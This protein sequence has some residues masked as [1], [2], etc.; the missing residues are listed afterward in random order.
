METILSN[1]IEPIAILNVQQLIESNILQEEYSIQS[2][3][4]I[5]DKLQKTLTEFPIG[6]LNKNMENYR[7]KFYIIRIYCILQLWDPSLKKKFQINLIELKQFQ[8]ISKITYLQIK[9]ITI[10]I[11]IGNGADRL[12]D[13]LI[14]FLQTNSQDVEIEQLIRQLETATHL[15]K[16]NI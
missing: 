15:R 10:V 3:C 5:L 11:G 7:Y 9:R 14:N 4:Y 12:E 6:N 1:S 2:L 8:F 16:L 13:K